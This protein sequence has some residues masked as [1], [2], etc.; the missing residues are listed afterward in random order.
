MGNGSNVSDNVCNKTISQC[1]KL[2]KQSKFVKKLTIMMNPTVFFRGLKNVILILELYIQRC[3]SNSHSIV[4]T[5]VHLYLHCTHHSCPIFHTF[6]L[7]LLLLE[8][9][10]GTK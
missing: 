1:G 10:L 3:T 9:S 6:I 2:Q 8:E 4:S 7:I 5:S